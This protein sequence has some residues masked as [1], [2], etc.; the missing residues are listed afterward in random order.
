MGFWYVGFLVKSS[1]T[2]GVFMRRGIKVKNP[3]ISFFFKW[4]I[5]PRRFLIK[6]LCLC[7][8]GFLVI[9]GVFI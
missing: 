7:V 8:R 3:G 2:Y 4:G 9:C 5:F 1:G 6:I